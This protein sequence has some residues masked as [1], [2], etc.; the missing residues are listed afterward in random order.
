MD[1]K[2]QEPHITGGVSLVTISEETAVAFTRK[3]NN[4]INMTDDDALKHFMLVN[5]AWTDEMESPI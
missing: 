5:N 2:F 4:H 1:I 3:C